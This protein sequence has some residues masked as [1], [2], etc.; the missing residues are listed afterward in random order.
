MCN[1]FNGKDLSK[2]EREHKLGNNVFLCL[3]LYMLYACAQD[4]KE[5]KADNAEMGKVH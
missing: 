2:K 4:D 1:T 3:I 5:I